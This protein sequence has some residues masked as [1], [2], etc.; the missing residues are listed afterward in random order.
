MFRYNL[1]AVKDEYT[2]AWPL[3]TSIPQAD[4]PKFVFRPIPRGRER[5]ILSSIST[6]VTDE[7]TK[8]TTQ[9]FDPLRMDQ[10]YAECLVRI[11]NIELLQEDGE[12]LPADKLLGNNSL[13]ARQSRLQNFMT[14]NLRL[15]VQV[16][17]SFEN[18]LSEWFNIHI[19]RQRQDDD[20]KK[21]GTQPNEP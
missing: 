10:L 11:E 3:G 14:S 15:D 18:D 21:N 4:K 16:H 19:L 2:F 12:P 7:K 20:S 6:F 5:E 17:G 8:K 13:D 9:H 1:G